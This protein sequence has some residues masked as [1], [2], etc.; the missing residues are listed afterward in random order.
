MLSRW[1]RAYGGR[2]ASFRLRRA[3]SPFGRPSGSWLSPMTW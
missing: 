1:V 3:G 2:D